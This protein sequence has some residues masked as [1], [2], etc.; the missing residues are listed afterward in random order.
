ML[1]V[2][3]EKDGKKVNVKSIMGLMSFVVSIGIEVILIVQGED[4]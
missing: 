3:F 2:F 1:D 4:E